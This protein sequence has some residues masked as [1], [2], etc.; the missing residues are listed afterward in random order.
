MGGGVVG[1]HYSGRVMPDCQPQDVNTD[2]QSGSNPDRPI[3][4]RCPTARTQMALA[5]PAL[6][7]I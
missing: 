1:T 7:G 5:A 6:P 4:A 2:N 3:A